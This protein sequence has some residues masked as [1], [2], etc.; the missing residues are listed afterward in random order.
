M[1]AERRTPLHSIA[2]PEPATTPA[3]VLTPRVRRA[4]LI[5]GALFAA[6]FVA[7]VVPRIRLHRDLSARSEAT[8]NSV[9]ICPSTSSPTAT[10]VSSRGC[11]TRMRATSV[12]D[13][14]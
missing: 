5:A 12:A 3:T 8:R 4:L 10:T 1:S 2:E 7:G 13:R 14:R 9:P 11:V 6:L